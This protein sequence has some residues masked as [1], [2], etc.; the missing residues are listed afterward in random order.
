MRMAEK[1]AKWAPSP[2]SLQLQ[3][4]LRRSERWWVRWVVAFVLGAIA[5][6]L[7]NEHCGHDAPQVF[8]GVPLDAVPTELP[9]PDPTY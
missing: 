2:G 3:A 9:H 8:G 4:A 5:L 1:P 6:V 7:C